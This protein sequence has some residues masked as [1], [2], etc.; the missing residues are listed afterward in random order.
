MSLRAVPIG[1]GREGRRE[2]TVRV[3]KLRGGLPRLP[4]AIQRAG[5]RLASR[6]RHDSEWTVTARGLRAV[7]IG[8]GREGRRE[9]TVRV[10]KLRGGLPGLP[11]ATQRPGTRLAS[12]QRHDSEWTVTA[13]GLRAVPIDLGRE[14][15]REPTARVAK[16]RGGLPRLPTA[17]QRRVSEAARVPPA[18]CRTLPSAWADGTMPE[19]GTRHVRCRLPSPIRP[20]KQPVRF[21]SSRCA[22]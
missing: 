18:S 2:P 5:P 13:R 19:S 21:H 6:Q 7:P 17:L 9:P 12:R 11:T 8:L 16:L 1:L 22:S 10:A 20:S 4:T 3:A 14:G 15:R